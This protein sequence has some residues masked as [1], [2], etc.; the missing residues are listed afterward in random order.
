[1]GSRRT[2]KNTAAKIH[3]SKMPRDF[4]D[5]TSK[6]QSVVGV[7]RNEAQTSREKSFAESG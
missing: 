5:P 3:A 2:L 7:R 1:M 4:F 6:Q